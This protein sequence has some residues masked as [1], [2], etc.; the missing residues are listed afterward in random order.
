[1]KDK[2]WIAFSSMEEI[3]GSSVE[4]L[5]KY[6][7]YDIEKA[8]NCNLCDLKNIENISVKFAEKFLKLRDKTD[9]DKCLFEVTS[10]DINYLTLENNKYPK[11]LKEINNPPIIL[12]YKGNLDCCNFEKTIA[13]VGSRK[14]S[15]NGKQ[16]LKKI[17]D[18]FRNTDIC[19]VSG[20]ALGIDTA[21]HKL[22][23]ENNLKTIGVIASGTDYIYPSQNKELY[24]QIENNN[25][26]IFTEYYPTFRPLS[27]RFPQR[28]RIVTGLSF[29]TIVVEAAIKSGALISANLTLEQGRELMCIPG[30]I[31]NPNTEGIYKLLK[32]GATMITESNDVLEALNWEI[33]T[34]INTKNDKFKYL[35]DEE[36]II[37]NLLQIEPIA[38]DTIQNKTKINTDELLTFLTMLELKGIIN[39]VEGDRYTVC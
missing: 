34:E 28:N 17:I 6:Y 29:G 37:I 2:Y 3:G 9:P 30:N 1:M 15:S 26:L 33:K 4:K 22:A 13:V 10:R 14:A 35:S 8:Y 20:L 21:A 32:S 5:F 31:T 7:N 12:Y 16:S 19:I 27:F 24:A 36:Q 39:Q 18:G 11:L 25:G 38:F 23:I